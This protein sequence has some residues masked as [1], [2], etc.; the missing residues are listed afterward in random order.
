MKKLRYKKTVKQ[1]SDTR[2]YMIFLCATVQICSFEIK[3]KKE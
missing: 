1:L 2:T 3:L